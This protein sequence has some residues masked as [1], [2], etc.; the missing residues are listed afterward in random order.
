M[1]LYEFIIK[2]KAGN[3]IATLDSARN[4]SWE[5]YLNRSGSASFN[6]NLSDPKLNQDT[7]LLGSKELYIYRDGVLVWGGELSYSRSNLITG[8]MLVTAKGFFD[9]LSKKITGTSASPRTF[10]STDLSQI[11]WTLIDEA[12]TGSNAS[13]GITQ[14][15]L[16]T[17]R[18]ADRSYE[19]KTVKE[20]IEGLTNLNIQQGIDFEIDANKQFSTFYPQKG[21]QKGDIV[22]EYGRNIIDLGET[23]D[24]TDMA[25]QVIVLGEGQGSE[26]ITVTR[27]SGGSTQTDYKIRQKTVSFKDVNQTATLNDHGDKE[28]SLRQTQQQIVSLKTKGDLDPQV[29]SYVVG[30]SVRVIARFGFMNIDSFF[31]IY[32]IKVKVSD[33]DEEEIELIFNPQ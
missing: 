23:L 15:T 5:V 12:Q 16:A 32:G 2:D 26:L 33:Q 11:A 25:N 13:F 4:R 18:N 10:S 27:D 8:E 3:T 20:A 24:A 31:R 30:D 21:T 17:S 29:G 1:G 14:G 7:L 6:V 9:L 22:F 19:Y 28:L